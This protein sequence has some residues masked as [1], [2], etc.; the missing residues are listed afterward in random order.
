MALTTKKF[1]LIYS[2]G[3][4]EH[5][6]P[7][8]QYIQEMKKVLAD[9]GYLVAFVPARVSLWKL[10]ILATRKHGFERSYT[11][12]ALR[13]LFERNGLRV[14]RLVGFD[15]FSINGF[16]MKLLGVRFRPFWKKSFLKSGYTEL[17]IVCQ[18]R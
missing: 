13:A 9:D 15:P 1:N 4:I 6:T 2:A 10:W 12:K 7:E 11:A 14:V 18:K 16:I 8:D 17:C 5:L 3:L